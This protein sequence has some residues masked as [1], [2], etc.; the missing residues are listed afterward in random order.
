MIGALPGWMK[1]GSQTIR[2]RLRFEWF[3]R[4]RMDAASVP[5]INRV[6]FTPNP[7]L[8]STIKLSSA[9]T[10]Y[11]SDGTSYPVTRLQLNV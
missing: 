3:T 4:R 2:Y 6:D 5:K 1:V 9:T 10:V 11:A 7:T 8:G